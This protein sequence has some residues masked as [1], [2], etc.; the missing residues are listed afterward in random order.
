V[1]SAEGQDMGISLSVR[2]R[3]NPDKIVEIHKT[4][5]DSIEEKVL[6]PEIMRTVKDQATLRM[7]IDA[8]SGAGLVQL[9]TDIEAALADPDSELSQ[10]GVV[11]ENFVIENIQLDPEYIGEIKARQVAMQR[12]L[13]AKE[14]EKAALA[15][16]QKANAVAQ[17]GLEKSVVEGE[18]D[19]RVGILEAEKE[20]AQEVLA[21][22]AAAEKVVLA[23]EASKR[24]VV[25]AAEGDKQQVVLAAEGEMEAGQ[26]KAQ[27]ILVI[28]ESEAEAT[29]LRLSAYSAAGPEAFVQIEVSRNMAEA[30]KN[31][32]GYLPQDMKI[33]L[34]SESFMDA[35][36]QVVGPKQAP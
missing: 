8:Y 35:V 15:E 11:V 2:W 31:I 10:R 23:A 7:A 22:G 16:A 27:A 21:A 3:I 34:L 33:N 4:I 13:R 20:A 28:G 9:Q 24:R 17:A 18:R 19:K 29:R 26:L 14:E 6:R 1:Q 12:E 5:R 32:N 36:Q 25:L 30:F